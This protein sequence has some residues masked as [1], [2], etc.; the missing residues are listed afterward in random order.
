MWITTRSKDEDIFVELLDSAVVS[1]RPS[2]RP[3]KAVAL[4]ILHCGV[5]WQWWWW[6]WKRPTRV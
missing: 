4:C 2:T 6:W 3:R 1:D 5:L